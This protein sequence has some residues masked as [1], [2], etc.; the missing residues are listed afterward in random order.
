MFV[1]L[2]RRMLRSFGG[3]GATPAEPPNRVEFV[4]PI[5]R[6]TE[7]DGAILTRQEF[8]LPIATRREFEG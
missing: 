8:V 7:F 1:W 3:T 6:R 4:L 5:T 2:F